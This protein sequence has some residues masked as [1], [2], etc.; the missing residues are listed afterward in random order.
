M[1]RLTAEM[2]SARAASG[3]LRDQLT[4]GMIT[5]GQARAQFMHMALLRSCAGRGTATSGELTWV[6][7]SHTHNGSNSV[8]TP[9]PTLSAGGGGGGVVSGHPHCHYTAGSCSSGSGGAGGAGASAGT[10]TYSAGGGGGATTFTPPSWQPGGGNTPLPERGTAAGYVIG[11]RW[12]TLAAP[13]LNRSPATA[14]QDW[15]PG[16]LRGMYDTWQPGV[17]HA[18]CKSSAQ[19]NH[20]PGDVP[21]VGDYC[22]FWAYWLM[23]PHDIGVAPDKL[24][25]CGVI[26][27]YGRTIIAEHGFRCAKARIIALH[28]PITIVPVSYAHPDPAA[29]GST[30]HHQ[31]LAGSLARAGFTGRVI[32]YGAPSYDD[33]VDDA[34]IRALARQRA[35]QDGQRCWESRQAELELAARAQDAAQAWLAVISD[36]LE[37]TY[38]GARVFEDRDAMLACFPPDPVYGRR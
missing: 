9:T 31:D 17:N 21:V 27:G 15:P 25:V 6:S 34:A 26:R 12:W 30:A 23:Q 2:E 13:D 20:A 22:G 7:L 29:A 3:R 8:P 11:Y 14:D 33:I 4:R 35:E 32:N 16:L 10:Y 36:R 28:V 5:V 38:P 37:Q 1:A 19:K 18:V 24:P